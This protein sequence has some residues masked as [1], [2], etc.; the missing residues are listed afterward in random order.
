MKKS[1]GIP[2][3]NIT[4]RETEGLPETAPLS[5]MEQRAAFINAGRPIPDKKVYR[6]N[7]VSPKRAAKIEAQRGVIINPNEFFAYHMKH[8]VPVCDECGMEASWLLDPIYEKVWRACHHHVLPKRKTMFPSLRDNL[9][10]H[11]V[12]FPSFGGKLCGCHGFAE[13]SWYNASTMKTWPK[14]V[15]IF[16]DLYPSIPQTE[17]KSIPEILLPY[18][19]GLIK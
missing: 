17:W 8:S 5:Y 15:Q 6:L 10:N 18:I 12:L 11:M 19:N 14:M 4:G 13:S 3:E 2:L 1:E 7:K 16:I 9:Q